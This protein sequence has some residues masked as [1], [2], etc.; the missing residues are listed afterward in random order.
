MK[1]DIYKA[2]RIAE[3]FT[4]FASQGDVAEAVEF[5]VTEA[6]FDGRCD[7]ARSEAHN[8]RTPPMNELFK[9]I[10]D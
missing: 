9:G 5:F 8:M 3:R 2:K 6:E 7:R 1:D 10:K 4:T